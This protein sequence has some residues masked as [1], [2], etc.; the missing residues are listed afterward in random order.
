MK[1]DETQG[2]SDEVIKD[3]KRSHQSSSPMENLRQLNKEY[4]ES[5]QQTEKSL[6]RSQSYHTIPKDLITESIENLNQYSGH[7]EEQSSGGINIVYPDQ[8]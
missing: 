3:G 4:G 2:P 8:I 5:H 7:D 1:Q 6:N